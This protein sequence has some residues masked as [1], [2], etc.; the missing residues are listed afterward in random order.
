MTA[1]DRLAALDGLPAADLCAATAAKLTEL[2]DIMNRE[3]LLLRTGKLREAGPITQQKTV[4]A[5]DYVS[6]ARAVQRQAVRLEREAPQD[7]AQLRQ[8]H[9]RLATQMAENLRVIATAR[10][11]TE[12]LLSD[13]AVAVGQGARTRTYGGSGQVPPRPAP[14][15]GIAINRAL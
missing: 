14:A 6:M 15:T 13:V 11:V 8:G 10:A 9:D 2:A 1:A 12:D 7:L 5:Q 4:L 3:T